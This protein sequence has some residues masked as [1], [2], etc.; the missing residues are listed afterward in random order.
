MQPRL[1]VALL[2]LGCL[3]SFAAGAEDRLSTPALCFLSLSYLLISSEY[4]T[5]SLFRNT[6]LPEDAVFVDLTGEWQ[7]K[8]GNGSLNLKGTVPGNIHTDLLRAGIIGNLET[9]FTSLNNYLL[10]QDNRI[11]DIMTWY[12]VGSCLI[13]GRIRDHSQSPPR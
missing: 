9:Y 4:D 5:L 2:L 10:L 13:H 6:Q 8:N 11:T 7:I 12:C 3:L 1:P